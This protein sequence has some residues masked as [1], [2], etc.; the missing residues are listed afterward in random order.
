MHFPKTTL[1][2]GGFRCN[3]CFACMVVTGE[4]EVMKDDAQT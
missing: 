2:T 4:R 3:R 1:Q